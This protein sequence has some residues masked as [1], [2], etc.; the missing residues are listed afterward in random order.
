M[1][2]IKMREIKFRAWNNKEQ[3]MFYLKDPNDTLVLDNEQ[4]ELGDATYDWCFN[5]SASNSIC[6]DDFDGD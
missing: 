3:K 4:W 5:S 2:I 6:S 1:G